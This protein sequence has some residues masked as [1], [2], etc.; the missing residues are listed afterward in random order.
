MGAKTSLYEAAKL[1]REAKFD[2]MD[3][4]IQETA[5]LINEKSIDHVRKAFRD[6]DLRFG[7]WNL[8]TRWKEDEDIFQEDLKQLSSQA[9]LAKRLGCRRSTTWI[10]SYSDERPFKEN[11]EWHKNRIKPIADVL[12]KYDCSLALEFVGTKT[13]RM[14]H[15]YEFVHNL[16]G[17]LELLDGIAENNVGLLLDS[18]HWYVSDGTLDELRQLST[19]QVFYVHL[20]DAPK[21]ISR[22]K[23]VD[24]VRCLPGETGVI[25]LVG[26]LHCFRDMGYDGPVT[27][28]PLG[29]EKLRGLDA[30][31]AIHM[32][33]EAMN[34]VW[35]KA[36]L[37]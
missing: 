5:G 11:L 13:F 3:L 37:N 28:E 6:N 7:G 33:G 36:K 9:S 18:W 23:Q 8:P 21:N 14:G 24:L 32:V 29:S 2:G 30:S 10:T 27:P 12:K 17:T 20:N 15:K 34:T 19:K 22:D 4:D 16:E 1:A 31:R 35:K 26:F 25:D